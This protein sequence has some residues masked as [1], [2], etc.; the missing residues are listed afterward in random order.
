MSVKNSNDTIC[1][2]KIDGHNSKATHN[3][4]YPNSPSALRP[5]KH[6]D[7]LPVHKPLEQWIVHEEEPISTSPKD[8]SGPYCSN[9]HPDFPELTVLHLTSQ[10]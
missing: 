6:D 7:S 4:G 8:D 5:V 3:V 9:V 1:F 10:Y 2:T